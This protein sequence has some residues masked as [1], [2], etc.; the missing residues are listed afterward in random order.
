MLLCELFSTCRRVQMKKLLWY[1]SNCRVDVY[2]NAKLYRGKCRYRFCLKWLWKLSLSLSF[3]IYLY[4][5]LYLSADFGIVFG[6]RREIHY[7]PHEV[8]SRVHHIPLNF[9]KCGHFSPPRLSSNEMQMARYVNANLPSGQ[10]GHQR[11]RCP[12]TVRILRCH[13]ASS[14]VI[15]RVTGLSNSLHS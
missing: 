6:L 9:H 12:L 2:V 15:S 5:Y 7:R 14:A 1:I 10:H 13:Y 8:A 3:S 11:R 4:L